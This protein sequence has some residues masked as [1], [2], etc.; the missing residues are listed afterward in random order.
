MGFV[1]IW[2]LR[3]DYKFELFFWFREVIKRFCFGK[4]RRVGIFGWYKSV[5]GWRRE[6][7]NWKLVLYVIVNFMVEDVVGLN[8]I[9][10]FVV[11]V[12]FWGRFWVYN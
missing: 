4:M 2:C 3:K 9:N 8:V 12:E 11:M 1:F 5:W 6:V 7:Y 10:S